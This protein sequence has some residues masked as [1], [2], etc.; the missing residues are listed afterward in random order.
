MRVAG[1]E[2]EETI[3][4][5]VQVRTDTGCGW[6]HLRELGADRMGWAAASANVCEVDTKISPWGLD[7]LAG[8]CYFESLDRALP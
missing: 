7:R 2:A 4:S 1:A 8:T 6:C 3:Q 5:F